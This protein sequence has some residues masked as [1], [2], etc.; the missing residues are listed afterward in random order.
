MDAMAQGVPAV[1]FSPLGDI[2]DTIARNQ[3]KNRHEELRNNV[4]RSRMAACMAR[5]G[6]IRQG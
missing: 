5:H 1:D 3:E 2:G 4:M 6:Y